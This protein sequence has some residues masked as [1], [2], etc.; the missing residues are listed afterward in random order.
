MSALRS[1]LPSTAES[2]KAVTIIVTPTAKR[3]GCYEARLGDGRALD[4]AP[5]QPFVDAARRLLALGYDPTTVLVMRHAG[6]D[7]DSLTAQ[8]GAAA[9]LRVKEDRGGP[10]FVLWEPITRRVEA[11]ASAKAKRVARAAPDDVN[12]PSP[13]PGAAAATQFPPI[14]PKPSRPVRRRTDRT[15]AERQRPYRRRKGETVTHRSAEGGVTG[16]IKKDAGR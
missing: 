5:R 2:A 6:S 15:T 11:L 13:R 8:I 3:P 14:A 12:E 10:R 16:K 9:K 4:S 7:T 1:V